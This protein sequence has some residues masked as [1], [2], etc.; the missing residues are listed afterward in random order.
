MR[1]FFDGEAKEL[2]EY[3]VKSN[4]KH[5]VLNESN[6]EFLYILDQFINDLI[7]NLNSDSSEETRT[8]INEAIELR[9]SSDGSS[10]DIIIRKLDLFFLFKKA[11]TL[12]LYDDV[13]WVNDTI[14]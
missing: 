11:A 13:S 14:K 7:E 10:D 4:R 9:D 1:R 12:G 5:S 2:R 3:A 6:E 8:F